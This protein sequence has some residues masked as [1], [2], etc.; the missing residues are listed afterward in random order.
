MQN[1]CFVSLRG[2]PMLLQNMFKRELLCLLL[3]PPLIE[4]WV[5]LTAYSKFSNEANYVLPALG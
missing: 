3:S 1:C 5:V 4:V 2:R